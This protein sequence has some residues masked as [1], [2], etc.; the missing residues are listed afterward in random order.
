LPKSDEKILI[1]EVGS[2][3]QDKQDSTGPSDAKTKITT[4]EFTKPKAELG[5]FN[6]PIPLEYEDIIK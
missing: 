6:Q 5:K 2:K 4:Q 1:R 3:D